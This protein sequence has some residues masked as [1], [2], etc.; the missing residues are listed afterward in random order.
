MWGYGS[1]FS[2]TNRQV[3]LDLLHRCG[4]LTEEKNHPALL[5][6]HLLGPG[7]RGGSFEVETSP[8]F[9]CVSE[10]RRKDGGSVLRDRTTRAPHT[11][12]LERRQPTRARS[13][14]PVTEAGRM[15]ASMNSTQHGI[16]R[17]MF[18]GG[19]S[20][21]EFYSLVRRLKG[22]VQALAEVEAIL[23]EKLASILWRQARFFRTEAAEIVRATEFAEAD[24]FE[25]GAFNFDQ[26]SSQETE[27]PQ[28][29]EERVGSSESPLVLLKKQALLAPSPEILERLMGYERHL[30]RELDRVLSQIEQLRRMRSKNSDPPTSSSTKHQGARRGRDPHPG[31][32]KPLRRDL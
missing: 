32:N 19:E 8:L 14:G 27:R 16:F 13:T 4:K 15:R 17:N 10:L 7:S 20:S 29:R 24:R 26:V 6:A 12:T 22:D 21:R 9:F 30:G 18:I 31:Q 5:L 25:H 3:F 11:N 28:D 23:W 1:I 2:E